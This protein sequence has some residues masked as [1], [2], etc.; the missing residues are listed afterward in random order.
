MCASQK[1]DFSLPTVLPTDY[2]VRLP[3]L[4]FSIL[5]SLCV[6]KAGGVA[7]PTTTNQVQSL[8]YT[9]TVGT[10]VGEGLDPANVVSVNAI[11]RAITY[12][13]TISPG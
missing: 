4:F 12:C 9:A 3:N 13:T 10:V 5:G 1:T 6:S 11:Q 7:D 8:T 2:K